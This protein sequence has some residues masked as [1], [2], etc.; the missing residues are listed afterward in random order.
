MFLIH[1]TSHLISEIE[2]SGIPY[3][4]DSDVDFTFEVKNSRQAIGILKTIIDNFK[5]EAIHIYDEQYWQLEEK[6]EGEIKP[7]N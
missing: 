6:C 7:D 3:R 2:K 4:E 1:V 5:P